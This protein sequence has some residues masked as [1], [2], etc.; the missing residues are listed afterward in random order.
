MRTP[1]DTFRHAVL[2]VITFGMFIP[3]VSVS[4]PA[5]AR[6]QNNISVIVMGEDEDPTSFS[7]KSEVFKQV[8]AELKHGMLRHGFRIR[9]EE[10]IAVDL[11]WK[12]V[13]RRP[14][15]QLIEAAKL[16]NHS[17]KANLRSRAL[18]L[19]R[20]HAVKR[21]FKHFV[22]VKTHISGELYD[23]EN[24]EF[25]GNFTLSTATYTAPLNC[26]QPC[27]ANVVGKRANEIATRIG[28]VLGKELAYLSAATGRGRCG[29]S[30]TQGG[31]G[32]RC[33]GL[34]STYTVTLRHFDAPETLQLINTM[35]GEFPC[36][37]SHDLL[38]G[39][40]SAVRRYEYVSRAKSGKIEEWLNIVLMDMGL[41]PDKNV[42]IIFTGNEFILDKIVLR[43]KRA[44]IRGDS[45]F[46]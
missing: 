3:C 2:A 42:E 18:V 31:R 4:Y 8:L 12:V 34:Q 1:V 24:N 9:D 21:K 23:L 33:G 28:D 39:K 30:S 29:K 11:G 40:T 27:I 45:R 15:T 6:S 5:L 10:M 37:T 35:A 22:K 26:D 44:P 17:A 20:I 43:P 36:Y 14:K 16:A 25:L 41:N 46:K 7:R 19:F 32:N 38:P 13:E